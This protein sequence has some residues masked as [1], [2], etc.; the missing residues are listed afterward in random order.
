MRSLGGIESVR[1]PAII[2]D[3]IRSDRGL[4]LI[5]SLYGAAELEAPP[6][7]CRCR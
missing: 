3:W 4:S 5:S 6:I 2:P 7:A 1:V